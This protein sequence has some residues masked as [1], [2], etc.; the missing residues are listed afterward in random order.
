[1]LVLS[2]A[3]WTEQTEEMCWWETSSTVT[4]F[5]AVYER[6]VRLTGCS[7]FLPSIKHSY[8][9]DLKKCTSWVNWRLIREWASMCPVQWGR[10]LRNGLIDPEELCAFSTLPSHPP[11]FQELSGL[12]AWD[13]PSWGSE[14][15]LLLDSVQDSLLP[16]KELEGPETRLQWGWGAWGG[17][18]S[19]YTK[20]KLIKHDSTVPFFWTIRRHKTV[21]DTT[22][23]G[24]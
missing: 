8:A 10:C 22:V 6:D 4:H 21:S 24:S 20:P 19:P 3:V 11:C 15:G 12:P 9:F 13:S 5:I 14:G 1:M 23:T 16:F 2:A 18:C 17:G 7:R